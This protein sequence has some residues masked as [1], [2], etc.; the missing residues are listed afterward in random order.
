[1]NRTTLCMV[2]GLIGALF[3]VACGAVD[4]LGSKDANAS[5]VLLVK[6]VAE[7]T[8]TFEEVDAGDFSYITP[9][10]GDDYNDLIEDIR[11]SEAVYSDIGFC[12]C[13]GSNGDCDPDTFSDS[14]KVSYIQ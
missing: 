3:A 13:S 4:G 6:Y 5:D 12:Y 14:W 9:I 11:A 1:M 2:S 7:G 10:Y 8:C